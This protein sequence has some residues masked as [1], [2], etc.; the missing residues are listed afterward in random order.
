MKN[1]VVKSLTV[2]L[3]IISILIFCLSRLQ[4]II[5]NAPVGA[6]LI[7]VIWFIFGAK[8]IIRK[9][10]YKGL[11]NES[12]LHRL[13]ILCIILGLLSL[14]FVAGSFIYK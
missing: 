1:K 10:F 2:D 9:D 3:I 8:F 14:I 6:T 13:A 5:K 4:F 7:P 12:S 11:I